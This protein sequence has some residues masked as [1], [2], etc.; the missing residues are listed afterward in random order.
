MVYGALAF[1]NHSHMNRLFQT[2]C[3][4]DS[5]HR[6]TQYWWRQSPW[7]PRKR[8]CISKPTSFMLENDQFLQFVLM[9]CL[10]SIVIFY[11]CLKLNVSNI[12]P[13]MWR[14]E[15][16]AFR[17]THLWFVIRRWLWH[18]VLSLSQGGPVPQQQRD[19]KSCFYQGWFITLL[20]RMH[21]TQ[22]KA[23]CYQ[24]HNITAWHRT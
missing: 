11:I 18:N 23:G 22:N 20:G 24:Y 4:L 16:T 5:P 3:Y 6:V 9:I 2:S 21:G 15:I 1:E 19:W 8:K 7:Q 12:T 14:A 17:R 13:T 10:L